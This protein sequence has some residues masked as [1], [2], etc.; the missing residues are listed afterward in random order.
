MTELRDDLDQALRSVPTGE[1]PVGRA[2]RDGRRLR[3]RRRLAVLASA[4]AV[5]A[6]AA[7]SPSLARG[8]AAPALP[9]ASHPPALL[10]SVTRTPPADPVVTNQPPDPGA[11]SGTVAQGLIG[12]HR[13]AVVLA[14]WS[15]PASQGQ[16][17]ACYTAYV[18][19]A[20]GGQASGPDA[21]IYQDCASAADGLVVVPGTD[22]AGLAANLTSMGPDGTTEQVVLG[23]VAADVDYFALT[24]AD[25][26]QLKLI[27]VSWHGKRYVAWIASADM[28]IAGLTAHLGGPNFDNGQLTTAV[29]F[30]SDG[31]APQF[32]L[33]LAPGQAGPPWASG[34]IGY[35]TP[36]GPTWSASAYEGP[37]GT[38]FLPELGR[39]SCVWRTRLADTELLGVGGN[40][41]AAAFGSAA[42]GVAYLRVSLS[43]GTTVQVTPVSVGNERLFALWPGIGVTATEWTAYDAAGRVLNAGATVAD[44]ASSPLAR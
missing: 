37:W 34:V 38:C 21:H 5:A 7:V 10:P 33:W 23:A 35:G 17:Y 3:N 25:G 30:Q 36:G 40:P 6:V 16:A 24:F 11:A 26:Q 28:T 44:A 41:P 27:P 14:G 19:R 29:P 2:M 4:L 22:P 39:A 43:N 1:A 31:E 13:W 12:G 20:A 42:P 8:T 18:A 15:G 32:G 9:A